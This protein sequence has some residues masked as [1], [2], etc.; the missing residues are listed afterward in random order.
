MAK[1]IKMFA[2]GIIRINNQCIIEYANDKALTTFSGG[3]EVIGKNIK[4]LIPRFEFI[5]NPDAPLNQVISINGEKYYITI[6]FISWEGNPYNLV[7]FQELHKMLGELKSFNDNS[8]TYDALR[9]FELVH[10]IMTITDGQGIVLYVSPSWEK[11]N[12]LAADKIIGKHISNLE[13]DEIISPSA[14]LKVLEEKSKVT[15]LQHDNN[16]QKI[17]CTGV[18]VFNECNE[19]QWVVSYDSWD[20]TNYIELKEHYERLYG[21]MEHYA[22]EIKVK[23]ISKKTVIYKSPQIEN[24]LKLS[25]KVAQ[26]NTNILITGESGVGKNLLATLIHE[27]STFCEGPLID[28]NCGAIPDN[29]IESELFGYEKGA[30]TGAKNEGKIGLIE[31]AN[32][33][34]LFLDE[35]GELP[36]NLQVKLLKV[37]Q[38]KKITRVGGTKSISVNFRLISATNRNLMTLVKE[39][40]FREDLYYRLNV[41]PINIPP[42]RERSEDILIIL[43]HLVEEMN[44]RH[45]K[46]K[47]FSEQAISALMSYSWPGNVR[48]LQNIVERLILTS[49][50]DIIDISCLPDYISCLDSTKGY[51]GMNLKKM[52]EYHERE[53]VLSVYEKYKTTVEVGRVLGISQS[54]AV[55]KLKKHVKNYSKMD[56]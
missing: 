43:M 4:E 29:L 35:V 14:T 38:E 30:F 13:R 23:E 44:K 34:T 28:I 18:P 8:M 5:N 7:L 6:L 1:A 31:L 27:N 3:N 51:K 49:D 52:L 53:L 2:T 24:I 11:R 40:K 32:N 12:K 48:E 37:I 36:L 55:R 56:S 15:I 25:M 45:N 22:E 33:G 46:N 10:D 20:I 21:L 19:I 16:G 9:I 47:V 17:L 50:K 42:L 26:T 41:V 39:G 54:S